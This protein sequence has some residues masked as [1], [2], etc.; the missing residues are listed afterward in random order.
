MHSVQPSLFRRSD[1]FFGV[2]EALGEDFGFNP[3]LLRVAFG[4]LLLWNPTV[5]IGTY[6]TAA[7]LILLSRWIFPKNRRAMSNGSPAIQADQREM[8]TLA[9]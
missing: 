5:V 2:C 1:T 7:V 4:V 6:L 8:L 9:G 3:L